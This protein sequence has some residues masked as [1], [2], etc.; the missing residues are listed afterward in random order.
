MKRTLLIIT[1]MAFGI[2]MLWTVPAEAEE[3]T[4]SDVIKETHQQ[5]IKET[6][7]I[8]ECKP[9]T[10]QVVSA[11]KDNDKHYFGIEQETTGVVENIS[12]SPERYSDYFHHHQDELELYPMAG[13]DFY[14]H[15]DVHGELEFYTIHK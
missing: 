8:D 6:Y 12:V 14:A 3:E 15:E 9:E 7:H 2:G 13:N 10:F 1:G 5:Y 11:Y 4:L